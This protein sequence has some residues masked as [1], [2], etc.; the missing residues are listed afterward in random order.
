MIYALVSLILAGAA[1]PTDCTKFHIDDTASAPIVRVDIPPKHPCKVIMKHGYPIPDPTCTPGAYNPT[2][3]AEILRDPSFTTKCIRNNASSEAAKA[4]TYKWYNIPH[5]DKNTGPT[6]TC[7]LDHLISLELGGADTLDNI[8]PQCGPDGVPVGQKFFKTKDAVEN[9]LNRQ[10]KS[11]A[12]SVDDA[13]KGVSTDWTQY[14][15]AAQESTKSKKIKAK[16]TNAGPN[17]VPATVSA[18]PA[19]AVAPV[20]TETPPDHRPLP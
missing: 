3:T 10:V 16:T 7:E 4:G 15:E 20:K 18:P 6:Q 5:P 12:M 13:R 8:W 19:K 2:M 1:Q 9:Y 11:G 17:I 14:I